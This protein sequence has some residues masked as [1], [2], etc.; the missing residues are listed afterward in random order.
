MSALESSFLHFL[1]WVCAL[2]VVIGH[3]VLVG[4][5]KQF[6]TYIGA[7]AHAAV[8][9]FFV[10]SGYVIA[11]STYNKK[12]TQVNYKFVH[13]FIDRFSRIYSV[14]IPAIL[15]TLILDFIGA[16]FFSARYSDSSL[17]PQTNQMIR[18][19]V[20]LF[21]LQGI[22]GFRVQL[23]SNPA[24]WSI[25]YEFIYYIVF[26]FFYFKP[27]R[28]KLYIL[29]VLLIVGYKIIIY[30]FIWA[31]GVILFRY[32]NISVT[33]FISVPLFFAANH[34]FQYQ[35]YFGLNGYLND[36]LFSLSV[37][38]LIS[39]KL[40]IPNF[41]G[42]IS[43][44]LAEFSFS[45]YAYHMPILYFCYSLTDSKSNLTVFLMVA[46]SVIMARLLYQISEKKRYTFKSFLTQRL[47]SNE[48]INQLLN[49]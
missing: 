36:F 27:K 4:G 1:R 23:G 32:K 17:F 38:L 18:F 41:L 22:W 19:F 42:G 29:F 9:V 45:L 37:M 28:Y 43:S 47:S 24:L 46:L 6:V 33:Y 34:I 12:L 25:G 44:Y 26:G 40:T 10:L 20:N 48:K 13:Y 21:S 49:I 16:F 11:D 35:N 2:L 15:L 8:I 14:L 31:L 3:V 30:G 7:H 5:G 39:S